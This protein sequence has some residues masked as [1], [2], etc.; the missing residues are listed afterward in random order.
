MFNR[1]VDELL[2][3]LPQLEGLDVD[4]I[5]RTLTRA[6]LE[7]VDRRDLGGA[8]VDGA[9]LIRDLRRLAT[10]LEVHAILR[11]D[12]DRRTLRACAFVAAEA[13]EVV[14][15][16]AALAPEE[17]RP[18]LFGSHSR[19]ERVEAGLLYLIAGY[20]ANAALIGRN[21]DVPGAEQEIDDAAVSV[22]V[23]EAT[24]ALLLLRLPGDSPLPVPPPASRPLRERVRHAIW[25]RLGEAVRSHLLWLAL[26]SDDGD[27]PIQSV[28]DLIAQLEFHEDGQDGSAQH[29]DLHHL[30]LLLAAAIDE[31]AGRAL[32]AVPSPPDDGGRFGDYQRRRAETR[33]LLWPAAAD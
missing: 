29:A 15:E 1:G 27:G 19:F 14:Y 5:R 17:P 18:W 26:G 28:R 30:A 6:W 22:W 24:Q 32:R 8:G 7:V 33:P 16:T 11:D 9:A 2:E 4:G 31:T 13:L 20:D 12:I 23:L 25:V 3:A 21:I 10:A